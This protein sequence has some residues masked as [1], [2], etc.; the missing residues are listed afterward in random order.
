[1]ERLK[2]WGASPTTETP[3]STSDHYT[4]KGEDA[5]YGYCPKCGARGEYRERRPNGSDQCV[6]GHVYPSRDAV[7]AETVAFDPAPGIDLSDA[8]ADRM[9]VRVERDK[10]AEGEHLPT[11]AAQPITADA[12]WNKEPG[13]QTSPE[14][15]ALAAVYLNYTPEQLLEDV[16]TLHDEKAVAAAVRRLAASVLS[17]VNG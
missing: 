10:I 15:A 14:L 8:Y 16:N 9:A 7:K 4:D 17:Q 6:R 1:V 2:S 13:R 11:T 12:G 3:I 5:P